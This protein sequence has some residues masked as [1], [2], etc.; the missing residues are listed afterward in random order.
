M[1]H[2]DQQSV[3]LERG[4]NQP[5]ASSQP[6]LGSSGSRTFLHRKSP[7]RWKKGWVASPTVWAA[8]RWTV[9]RDGM[10]TKAEVQTSPHQHPKLDKRPPKHRD[11]WIQQ[12]MRHSWTPGP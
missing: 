6:A 4:Q 11:T 3:G 7:E 9:S 12:H 2:Q 8:P 1:L 10:H 5:R